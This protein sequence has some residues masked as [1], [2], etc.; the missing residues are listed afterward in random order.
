VGTYELDSVLKKWKSGDLTVE[1]AVGQILQLLEIMSYRV[2][3]LEKR[4]VA[5]RPLT[6][7]S[8]RGDEGRKE[9]GSSK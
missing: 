2:G 4:D 6:E 9:A 7:S 1:Q 8:L 3:M 5:Q